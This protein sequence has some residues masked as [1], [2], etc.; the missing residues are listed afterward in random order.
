MS[1]PPAATS[2]YALSQH[3][4]SS[5]PSHQQQ[6]PQR[7]QSMDVTEAQRERPHQT[8]QARGASHLFNFSASL[9]DNPTQ[10]PMLP[11]QQYQHFS[12]YYQ[13]SQQQFS[14]QPQQKQQLFQRQPNYHHQ[15]TYHQQ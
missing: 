6:H 5:L 10:Q 4:P 7:R 11:P 12:A 8:T 13:P 9:Q 1:A 14:H 3:S 2:I 15:Q